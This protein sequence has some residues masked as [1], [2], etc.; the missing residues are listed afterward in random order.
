MLSI[1]R[2]L[3]P[4]L[5]KFIKKFAHKSTLTFKELSKDQ[6]KNKTI[7]YLSILIQLRLIK[8]FYKKTTFYYQL[9]R[10]MIIRRLFYSLYIQY[11]KNNFDQETLDTFKT[12][13]QVGILEINSFTTNPIFKYEIKNDI[14]IVNNPKN[15]NN[16]LYNND[17]KKTKKMRYLIIDFK[18]LDS[19]IFKDYCYSFLKNRYS[20]EMVEY[21]QFL[22]KTEINSNDEENSNFKYL[23]NDNFI[24]K[25]RF[26][27]INYEELYNNIVRQR[28]SMLLESKRIFNI[29]Y[30]SKIDDLEIIKWVL[31]P[32]NMVKKNMISLMKSGI[33]NMSM[34]NKNNIIWEVDIEKIINF[35]NL[36][37][38][39]K[40]SVFLKIW[41]I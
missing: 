22:E 8:Y 29:L 15:K 7:I 36:Y 4:E 23:E 25:E 21:F 39:D 19:L 10:E 16:D 26:Y 34:V 28:I 37:L 35:L 32:K 6:P 27:K 38:L 30:K 13:I 41:M 2:D 18:Y 1:L 3:D 31:L 17:G 14:V 40:L 11:I 20:P 9:N 12:L 24:I 33:I 5:Q